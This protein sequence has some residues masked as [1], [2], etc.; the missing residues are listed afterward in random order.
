MAHIHLSIIEDE[1]TVRE[2]LADF[3]SAQADFV[4]HSVAESVETFL[5]L[6]RGTSPEILLLDINLPGMSGL[7]GIHL[8]Q[9]KHPNL[10]IIMLTSF[11]E[12]EHV[13]EALRR[14]AVGYLSK[15]SPLV[16]VREAIQTVAAG[17]SFMSPSIARHVVNFFRFRQRVN[18]PDVELTDRQK[19]ILQGLVDGKSYKMIADACG[20]TL[21]TV[22]DHIKKIYKKLQ[23]N[24]KGELVSMILGNR[25]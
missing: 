3:L 17:G 23:I 13:F 2:S 1:E 7:E 20:I 10:D 8:I 14:G 19:E 25:L 11:E 9:K 12:E 24:S 4:V 18:N 5:A 6:Q 21:E 16:M 22:R 15:R